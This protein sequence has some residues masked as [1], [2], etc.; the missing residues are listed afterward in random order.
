MF[1]TNPVQKVKTL[2]LY[3]ITLLRKVCHI[4]DNVE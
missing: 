2:I 4:W 3:S 1:Q